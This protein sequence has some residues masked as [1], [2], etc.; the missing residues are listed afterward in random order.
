MTANDGAE[1]FALYCRECIMDKDRCL[2]QG[3]IQCTLH[4]DSFTSS[5]LDQ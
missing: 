4:T 5:V 3:W 1:S 2:S